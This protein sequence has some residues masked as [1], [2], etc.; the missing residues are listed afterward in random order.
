MLTCVQLIEA[1]P[2]CKNASTEILFAVGA[3]PILGILDCGEAYAQYE[4][5][6]NFKGL[7]IVNLY[8]AITIFTTFLAERSASRLQSLACEQNSIL[9]KLNK[10]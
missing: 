4:K 1:M 6:V 2:A 3:N 5:L 10:K 7:L 9:R 8:L